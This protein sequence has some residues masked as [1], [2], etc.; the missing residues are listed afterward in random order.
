MPDGGFASGSPRQGIALASVD[1]WLSTLPGGTRPLLP[2]ELAKYGVRRFVAGWRVSVGFASMPGALAL[3]IL[4][5]GAFPYSPARIA[6]ADR[7]AGRGWP[8]VETDGV[9]CLLPNSASIDVD[10]P[11]EVVRNQLSDACSLVEASLAG[12]NR[13]DFLSEV[14]S[15]WTRTS[16]TPTVGLRALVRIGGPSRVVKVWRARGF[17]LVGDDA[18][19]CLRWLKHV[20]AKAEARNLVE[21]LFLWMDRPPYPDEYPDTGAGLRALVEARCPDGLALLEAQVARDPADLMVLFGSRTGDGAVLLGA[22]VSRGVPPQRPRANRNPSSSGFSGRV[23]SSSVAVPR[24]LGAA[25]VLRRLVT[26]VD[27][28]WIHGRD[29]DTGA[30]KLGDMKVAVLG[31]GSVGGPVAVR[32]AQAGVGSLYLVDGDLLSSA[33]V[34]RHPLG[35]NH[36]H[37][38]KA[39]D[40]ADDLRKRFPHIRAVEGIDA[41]WRVAHAT[42]PD[43]L[44][45]CDLVIAAMAD[46]TSDSM[47]NEWHVAQGRRKPILYAWT[48]AHACAGHAVLITDEGGC[49]RCG[50]SSTGTPLLRVSERPAGT[51]AREPA[52]GAVFQPYG[53]VEMAHVEALACEVATDALLCPPRA[54]TH[55]VWAARH[56]LLASTGGSWTSEWAA[57]HPGREAGA[58]VDQRTWPGGPCPTCGHPPS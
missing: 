5:D 6:L 30:R 54:S 38:S 15:Y 40:L 57:L 49:L 12:T 42:R 46:W 28:A 1:A 39:V 32:L 36:L 44:G 52:C 4:A 23:L 55:R 37:R 21:G 7:T 19:G 26:R 27:P 51:L 14:G 9:L 17:D 47:L 50:F 33:N 48:E 58:F 13:D 45:S 53:P 22:T 43:L 20:G 56:S 8:H 2:E 35:V 18:E 29:L 16:Y 25:T 31:C 11:V 3:D 24:F 41:D 34:G 10:A